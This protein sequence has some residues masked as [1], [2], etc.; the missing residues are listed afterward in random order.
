MIG[1]NLAHYRVTAKLGEGGMGEVYQAQD[2]KLGREVAI[3]V[4]PEAFTADPERLA[5]FEREARV[6][7]A[8]NHPNI[9]AI[10]ALESAEWEGTSPSPT[11]G[12][13][14]WEGTSPSPTNG[15]AEWE[16]TSPSPTNGNVDVGAPLAGARSVNFLVMELAAGETLAE[17]IG[18]G[19][20]SVEEVL[21]V[22]E[23]IAVALEAAHEKGIIH[24]DLKPANVKV[25]ED[26]NVKVLD[27]GLA[28]ALDPTTVS[29]TSQ[30]PSQSPLSLSPTLTAQM[31][32][33]NVLLG[34]AAYMSP[35]QAKGKTLDKRSDIWA[36]GVLL[37]EMLTGQR[38]FAGDSITDILADVLRADIDV[39]TLS[40]KIPPPLTDVL[41]RC[42]ERDPN[43]RLHDIADARVV[44]EDLQDGSWEI[45][46]VTETRPPRGF[47]L[48]LAIGGV[49]GLIVGAFLLGGLLGRTDP[50]SEARA[51]RFEIPILDAVSSR[52]AISPDGQKIAYASEGQLWVRSF[53]QLE[54]RVVTGG[55][56]ASSPFW[57]PDGQS[58][59]FGAEGSLWRIPLEGGSRSLVSDQSTSTSGGAAWLPDNRIAFTTGNS[60]VLEVSAIGGE[61]RTVIEPGE[62]EVD[63]HGIA[64][65]PDGKGYL[66]VVHKLEGQ[67]FDNVTLLHQDQ[68]VELV[69]FPGRQVSFPVYSET[70]HILFSA[71]MAL[72]RSGLW[73]V[74]FSL[75]TQTTSGE[76][77]LVTRGA[78]G[79]SVE[80]DTLVYSPEPG[81]FVNELVWVDRFGQ[82]LE[83][84]GEPQEGLYPAVTLSSAGDRAAY[85]VADL[86]GASLWVLDFG[87][88]AAIQVGAEGNARFGTPAWEPGDEQLVY[89]STTGGDDLRLMIKS[90]DS[91]TQA[92]VITQGH[93][94]LDFSPDGSSLVFVRPRPG[95]M[96][97]LWWKNLED[98]TESE[99][100][101][102]DTWDIQPVFSPDGRHVAF[103]SGGQVFVAKFPEGE[104]RWQVSRNSGSS[105]QWGAD[106]KHL[107]FFAGDDFFE[108]SIDPGP[109]FKSSPPLHLFSFK[110]AP[111][112][113][114]FTRHFAV[115]G[116]GERFLMVRVSGI[117]PG[118]V[119]HQ[120]WLEGLQR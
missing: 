64:A 82:V 14:E 44:I 120:N 94:S 22:A 97:D 41:R 108:A 107:Y 21:P 4:L 49:A 19:N 103:R 86:Q 75:E 38:L 83:A 1:S 2:T 96:N 29:G 35:E 88:G 77:F 60:G 112:D 46:A 114:D 84:L 8:L 106:G 57:S 23:Q 58:I 6:L 32:G 16:G 12:D 76:P 20:M 91:S 105:P 119:V 9:A 109:P 87:A 71:E 7:A 54:P 51:W 10:Y 115:D 45:P 26:G 52:P 47:P 28:K 53:D 48:G 104:P 59:G 25:D 99:F 13:A 73:A 111:G 78:W 117:P 43:R 70:G 5:R 92:D 110:Q 89:P 50:A 30:D 3:K 24:R 61:T 74:P 40:G 62:E 34:T 93:M 11:N 39:D 102:T 37:W 80:G 66:T 101:A 100:V 113:F 118:I 31:T 56:G 18:R 69:H 79:V 81:V 72:R 17:R 55:D 98:G 27:F 67:A 63:F 95:F 42:L 15:D 90:P 65:L 68:R 116:N 85:T 33:A 36:F